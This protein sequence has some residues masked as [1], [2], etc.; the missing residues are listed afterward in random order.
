M[1]PLELVLSRLDGAT[2]NSR[3]QWSARCPAHADR[4]PSLTI[5]E[6]DTRAVLLHCFAGCTVQA[7]VAA[8]GLEMDDLFPP[9]LENLKR[10]ELQAL[11]KGLRVNHQSH[12]SP[13]VKTIEKDL[14]LTLILL[15]DL[16]AGKTPSTDDQDAIARAITRIE[17]HLHAGRFAA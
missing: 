16:A 6:G 12:V 2:S 10:R 9:D 5:A 17:G 3:G 8:L 11:Q 14:L 7:I 13:L 15:Y 4:S 1:S